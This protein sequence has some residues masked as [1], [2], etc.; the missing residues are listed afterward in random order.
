MD[1]GRG[2]GANVVGMPDWATIWATT[3]NAGAYGCNW[4]VPVDDMLPQRRFA[5]RVT[6][7]E[8]LQ[9][10]IRVAGRGIERRPRS[11]GTLWLVS[12]CKSFLPSH[13]R[14]RLEADPGGQHTD[15][16]RVRRATAMKG[17]AI[18]FR[19]SRR[20]P[21]FQRSCTRFIGAP[22]LTLRVRGLRLDPQMLGILRQPAPDCSASAPARAACQAKTSGSPKVPPG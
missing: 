17:Q 22:S 21:G 14:R 11:R 6:M 7:R 18:P 10:G 1:I 9:S 5:L 19:D 12:W 13:R 8:S 15:R 2:A 20:L 4:L 3:G 16:E